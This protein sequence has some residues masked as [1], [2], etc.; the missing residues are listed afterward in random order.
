MLIAAI[1]SGYLWFCFEQ[2]VTLLRAVCQVL[3]L[4][5]YTVLNKLGA[6]ALTV[7]PPEIF[8]S[9]LSFFLTL[10]PP[11]RTVRLRPAGSGTAAPLMCALCY[12]CGINNPQ[13]YPYCLF[14]N[15]ET[16]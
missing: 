7:C 4:Y 9:S 6:T 1:V 11:L 8:L 13:T 5:K 16:E 2:F 3:K 15:T 10:A 14:Q 12:N